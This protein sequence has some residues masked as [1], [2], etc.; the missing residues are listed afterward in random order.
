MRI[1]LNARNIFSARSSSKA[2][3]FS[4]P[5]IKVIHICHHGTNPGSCWGHAVFITFLEFSSMCLVSSAVALTHLCITNLLV[6]IMIR[7]IAGTLKSYFH[8]R[9]QFSLS[10][11]R[12]FWLTLLELSSQNVIT[13]SYFHHKTMQLTITFKLFARI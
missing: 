6:T 9:G 11:L 10:Y 13:N 3:Q 4:Q 12:F 2:I 5:Q 7:A 1:H 8:S